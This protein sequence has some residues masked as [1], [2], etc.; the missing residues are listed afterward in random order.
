ML[1]FLFSGVGTWIGGGLIA[2]VIAGSLFLWHRMEYV[3]RAE[4]EQWK[5]YSS[6]LAKAYEKRELIIQKYEE[7]VKESDAVIEAMEKDIEKFLKEESKGDDPVVLN[8]DDVQRLREW[9]DKH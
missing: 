7:E 9:I 3:P 8:R 6:N 5:E 1:K 4:L 2:A